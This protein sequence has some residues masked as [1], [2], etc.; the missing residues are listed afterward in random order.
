[1]SDDLFPVEESLSPRL[2]WLR[3]HDVVTWRTEG[4]KMPWSASHSQDIKTTARTRFGEG[5]TED[6]AI[7]ALARANKWPL[8]TGA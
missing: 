4:C 8:W 2:R 7:V 1:M 3:E 5:D 6:E